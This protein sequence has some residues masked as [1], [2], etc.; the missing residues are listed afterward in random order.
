MA[1]EDDGFL[2]QNLQVQQHGGGSY[3]GQQYWRQEY[4]QNCNPGP[5]YQQYK[6]ITQVKQYNN[7]IQ[8]S[9][10]VLCITGIQNRIA[11]VTE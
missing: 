2:E 10:V 9:C 7:T 6:H 11:K 3:V 5:N 1:D 4:Q 8:Y